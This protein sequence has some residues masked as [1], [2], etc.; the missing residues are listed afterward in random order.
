[1]KTSSF[2][3]GKRIRSMK[4]RLRT[5]LRRI[6]KRRSLEGT[7]S[8]E[9]Q[10]GVQQLRFSGRVG[11]AHLA[12]TLLKRLTQ[13]LSKFLLLSISLFNICYIPIQGRPPPSFNSKLYLPSILGCFE[14]GDPPALPTNDPASLAHQTSLWTTQSEGSMHSRERSLFPPDMVQTTSTSQSALSKRTM[15]IAMSSSKSV[16][17]ISCCMWQHL[18]KARP[19]FLSRRHPRKLILLSPSFSKHL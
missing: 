1:M 15:I 3:S 9:T 13:P 11:P 12:L 7:V 10:L 14:L 4:R 5:P 8:R 18:P 17:P 2:T 16:P 19:F 6:L